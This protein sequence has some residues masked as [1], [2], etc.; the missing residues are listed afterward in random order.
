[1]K[2][3]QAKSGSRRI[4]AM[5]FGWCLKGLAVWAITTLPV[6]AGVSR[7]WTGGGVDALASTAENW[8]DNTAPVGGDNVVFDG[9]S[10]T[11][12]DWDLDISVV[13]W[14][15][16]AD[17]GG[18]VTIRTEYP[19]VPGGT[20]FTN[21]T[22]TGNVTLEGG[23][24]THRANTGDHDAVDRLAVTVGGDFTMGSGA[25]IDVLGRGFAANRGPGAG[26]SLQRAG[27]GGSHGGQGGYHENQ[28]PSPCYG[29]ITHPEMLGSGS[30]V[31]GGGAIRLMIAGEALI[32]GD[33]DADGVTN[34]SN[35]PSRHGGGAGGSIHLSAAIISGAG[36]LSANG[37]GGYYTGGGGRIAVIATN[38]ATLGDITTLARA[39]NP[40]LRGTAGTIFLQTTA[41]TQ[42]IIDHDNLEPQTA[43][44]RSYPFGS[45][46]RPDTELPAASETFAVLPV[47]GGDMQDAALSI[48]NGGLV[49]LTA[50]LRLGDFTW[51][52]AGATLDLN[53]YSLFL[54]AAEPAG[55]FPADYGGGAIVSNDGR[56][57]W[58]DADATVKLD[59]YTYNSTV[60]PDPVSPTADGYYDVDTEVTLTVT[61]DADYTFLWWKGD[62]PEGID[63]TTHPLTVTM[64]GRRDL[65]PVVASTVDT[66]TWTGEGANRLA[67]TDANW[68]P[69]SAP[70]SGHH[71]VFDAT[72][73]VECYWD[74]DIEPAS[75][76]QTEDYRW[77]YSDYVGH[78][79]FVRIHTRY[80][81]HGALTNLAIRGD[82]ILDGGAWT[83][84]ANTGDDEAADRLSVTVDGEFRVGSDAKINVVNRGFTSER[85]PGAGGVA[86]HRHHS[87]PGASH[88]GQ[89]GWHA[90]SATPA[91]TYGSMTAPTMLGSGA[92]GRGGGAILVH[93]E[94]PLT[95]DGDILAHSDRGGDLRAGS[96]GGSIYLRGASVSGSGRLNAEG[97]QGYYTGGGGRIAMILTNA[98]DFADITFE[99]FGNHQTES[100]NSAAGTIY[101]EG[102]DGGAPDTWHLIIDNRDLQT[103]E[104]VVTELMPIDETYELHPSVGNEIVDAALEIK[105]RGQ[106]QLTSSIR[107]GDFV[108]L[109]E[110]ST[111]D[112]NTFTLY[113]KADEPPGDFPGDYGDGTV[114]TNEGEIIWGDASVDLPLITTA[115]PNGWVERDPEG[116]DDFHPFGSQVTVT[117]HPDPGYAF[118]FWEGDIPEETDRTTNP[119][120][121]TMDQER[122]LRAL[123]ASS[124]PDTHTWIGDGEDVLA[125]TA[126]NW[127]PNVAP[128]AGA[129]IV[130]NGTSVKE[131]HWDLDIEVSS[132]TQE[133]GYEAY[134]TPAEGYFGWVVIQTK[135]LDQDYDFTNFVVTGDVILEDGTWT[136]PHNSGDDDAVDRMSVSVG[137]NFTLGEKAKIDLY[138]RGFANGR[139][140]GAGT[141]AQRGSESSIGASHGGLGGHGSDVPPA[142]SYGS[143]FRPDTLGSSGG[144]RGG[145]NLNL[146]VDGTATIDGVIDADGDFVGT[147]TYHPGAGGSVLIQAAGFEGEG[148]ITARGNSGY[149]SSG[150]GRIALIASQADDFGDLVL[151]TRTGTSASGQGVAG[152]GRGTAGTIYFESPAGG[153][154]IVDAEGIVTQDTDIATPLPA[155][156]NP[157]PLSAFHNAT[158]RMQDLA[159]VRLV[160]DGVRIRDLEWIDADSLL[161]LDGHTL[162]V[163]TPYHPFTDGDEGAVVVEDGGE[164]IWTPR[165]TLLMLR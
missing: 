118:V 148:S 161:Y 24:W 149:R 23:V 133:E 73:D 29:S 142:P 155:V 43:I 28:L 150:G 105:N 63:R 74:L 65:T 107:I 84:P 163:R 120:T 128:T 123:F 79:G 38:S 50:D 162:Y 112:L 15:Q 137:G 82:C 48:T 6:H 117:A 122:E 60:T 20:G 130:L 19:D 4:V 22:I 97:S 52:D 132:W 30:S 40:G 92:N 2:H 54:K 41:D 56:I 152:A 57:V 139:G 49:K 121:V 26:V 14:T 131:M 100:R 5:V 81:G 165:G 75:W 16:T 3:L 10:S 39:G 127:Y 91:P 17:Y 1:M 98:T 27:K 94:G 31:R 158:L 58:G 21:L 101:L 126:S 103:P 109:D 32:S 88:G 44:E 89:G 72:S 143:P 25:A 99:A 153:R 113:V 18:T 164:I 157:E 159:R 141:T 35:S 116:V 114:I 110:D 34:T 124:A 90:T 151:S 53:G 154:L 86:G 66:R 13:D 68:Y 125:S 147:T 129:H 146:S 8:S 69:A 87:E 55:A 42:L 61:P 156:L 140:P 102:W 11:D 136:H 67:S 135:Y 83:H 78:R 145:G 45:R 95:I 144:R 51:L 106:V 64:D 76:T 33:I 119:L 12:C 71:I 108:L 9:T 85:G 70:E 37:G 96:A 138:G 160:E 59:V 77:F 80:P 46:F 62:L 104:R 7:T 36:N 115:G 134:Y 47:V 93:A 111:I